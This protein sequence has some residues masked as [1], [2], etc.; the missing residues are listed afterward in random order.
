MR[1]NLHYLHRVIN[2]FVKKSGVKIMFNTV[3]SVRKVSLAFWE[4]KAS[5]VSTMKFSA[6]LQLPIWSFDSQ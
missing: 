6:F 4:A 3:H 2:A 1:R 5:T